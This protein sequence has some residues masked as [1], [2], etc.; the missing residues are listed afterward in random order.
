M[1]L[2][3]IDNLCVDYAKK[4]VLH[5]LHFTLQP[6]EIACLLGPSGCGKSSLLRAI[7]GFEP[8]SDGTVWIEDELVADTTFHKPPE[9]RGVGM[10]FQDFALFPH[11]NVLDNVELGLHNVAKKQ[12]TQQALHFLQRVDLANFATAWPHELSGGQKQRVAIARALAPSPTILLMDEPFSNLDP[13]L[14]DSLRRDLHTLLRET[15]TTC[16]FATHDQIDAFALGDWLGVI[17]QG[18]IAQWDSPYRVYHQPATRFIADFVGEGVFIS[19]TVAGCG[20][21]T[22]LGC[23]Q[24]NTAN[25]GN[26]NTQFDECLQHNADNKCNY[27]SYAQTHRPSARVEVLVR[28]DDLAYDPDSE[29]RCSVVGREFRGEYFLYSLRLPSGLIVLASIASHVQVAEGDTIGLRVE[30]DHVV[31]FD[32]NEQLSP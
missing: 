22:E 18:T 17:H 9:Q 27:F 13:E 3:Q 5:N 19:G 10:V 16:I 15:T 4:R 30:M 21:Q 6:G 8:V 24:G 28:P 11:L 31:T 23:I 1:S 29:I 14:R 26:L 2:L 32:L 20:V 12:R 7:G 25:G